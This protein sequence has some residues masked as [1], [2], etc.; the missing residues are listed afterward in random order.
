ME[1][2]VSCN[3]SFGLQR[4]HSGQCQFHYNEEVEMVVSKWFRMQE[5]GFYHNIFFELMLRWDKW[6]GVLVDYVEVG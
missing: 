4:Q 6:L 1:V 2:G 5:P 3:R